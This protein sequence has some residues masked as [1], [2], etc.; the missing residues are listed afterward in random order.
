MAT[1]NGRSGDYHDGLNDRE[2]IDTEGNVHY[3]E[4]QP[5]NIGH[6]ALD[7]AG[8][9]HDTSPDPR[10]DEAQGSYTEDRTKKI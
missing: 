10:V 8:S 6:T 5:G 2:T 9:H 7:E 3:P 4:H 1:R